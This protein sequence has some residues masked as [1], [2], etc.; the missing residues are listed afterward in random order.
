MSGERLVYLAFFFA[1][2]SI[3]E[4]CFICPPTFILPLRG[5]RERVGVFSPLSER[6]V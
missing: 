4:G 2:L 5:G 1:S 3:C 6:G